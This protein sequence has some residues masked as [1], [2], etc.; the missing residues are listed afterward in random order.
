M[1]T[2][3]PVD[4]LNDEILLPMQPHTAAKHRILKEYM[5]AWLPIMAQTTGRI[6][7][8]DGFA[9]SGEYDDGSIGSPLIAV[10]CAN[11]HV[12]K[13]NF[14]GEI[15]YIFVEL[16]GGRHRHLMEML[17]K[18]YGTLSGETYALLPKN[19]KVQVTCGDFNQIANGI[20]GDLEDKGLNLAPTMAFVDPF[21]YVA[22]DTDILARILRFKKCEL[23]VTYMSGFIDRFASEEKHKN[24][25]ITTLKISAEELAKTA[26]IRDKEEREV[27]WLRYLNDAIVGK[28]QLLMGSSQPI[29][30]LYFK[31]LDKSNNTMYYLAYFTKG[32]KGL[33]VMK[34]AMSKVGVQWNYRF[35]DHDFKPGQKSILD[36]TQEEPWLKE[37][38]EAI[39]RRFT[40][41][42]M[43]VFLVKKWVLTDT[44]WLPSSKSLRILEEDGRAM[45]LSGRQKAFSYPDSTWL[46]F[47]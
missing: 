23:L 6:V 27:T 19:Y 41:R 3:P 38:A 5:N 2:E 9:G 14:K 40:G 16:H 46:Q 47:T 8:F 15:V 10:D 30:K 36:Y 7:Y 28:A 21:G 44:I 34:R 33:E 39:H 45:Y 13:D 43:P 31:M 11:D 20:L 26:A 4:Q 1:V 32:V 22:L 24:S 12:L 42:K 37:E 18:K 29:Y 17:Q 25:I 35:S